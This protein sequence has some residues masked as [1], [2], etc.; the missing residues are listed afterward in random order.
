[1]DIVTLL[2]ILAFVVVAGLTFAAAALL[3]R[4]V[5][6]IRADRLAAPLGV[7]AEEHLSILRW[8]EQPSTGWARL[9]ER[10]GG[11][12]V[13]RN[14][15]L[16][17]SYRRRLGKAGFYDPRGVGLF[18]GAKVVL[19]LIAAFAYALYGMATAT[20]V[21]NLF[22]VSAV[23]AAIGFLVPDI[24]LRLR[25][26]QR[27]RDIT[28]SLPDILDLMMV[29]VEAG[30]G[31]DAAIARITEQPESQGRPLHDE[32][33]R[34]HLEVRAGR[35]REEALRALAD[36]VGLD[37]LKS[38]VVAFMQTDRLGTPLGR[39]LR[40]QAEASRIKRRHRA[41][42]KA[43]L[44]PLM[45]LLPTVVFLMPSFMMIAMAP[46]MLRIS[47]LLQGGWAVGK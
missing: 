14:T 24:Y 13:P 46:A 12:L 41:E 19:G 2:V 33:R 37:E 47:E 34:M 16:L 21:P 32:L 9:V 26:A 20:A 15:I 6:G 36:R 31:F 5:P 45:M 27:Q 8:D 35:P 28:N 29:C 17:A 11:P 25:I 38:L 3:F 40:I 23:L 22:S 10:F 44:A 7:S 1:M 43:Q 30:M 39:T 18:L 4:F 42:A